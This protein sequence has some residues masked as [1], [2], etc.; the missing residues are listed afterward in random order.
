MKSIEY[1]LISILI[2]AIVGGYF[3][4]FRR[5]FK[6]FAMGLIGLAIAVAATFLLGNILADGELFGGIITDLNKGA[7]DAHSVFEKIKLGT[8]CFYVVLFVV[9]YIVKN[10]AVKYITAP[11]EWKNRTSRSVNKTLG[12]VLL[13]GICAAG[14]FFAFAYIPF[15]KNLERG[16]VLDFFLNLPFWS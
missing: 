10:L 15:L 13:C 12:A 9:I 5:V 14:I 3:A 11:L 8:I 1:L 2:L 4:G 7:E 16:A 6:F